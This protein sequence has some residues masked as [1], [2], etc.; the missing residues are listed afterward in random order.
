MLCSTCT[1][2][3]ADDSK[4]C[5]KCGA[6]IDALANRSTETAATSEIVENSFPPVTL[7][8]SQAPPPYAAFVSMAL[9]LGLC[10]SVV[11]FNAAHNIGQASWRVSPISLIA[12]VVAVVLMMGMPGMWRRTES[13]PDEP[14][15]HKKLLRR[16]AFFVLLFVATA[17]VVGAKVG[18][19]G[20]EAGQLIADFREMSRIGHRISSARNSVEP[21]VPAQI[22]MYKQIEPEVRDFDAVLKRIQAELPVYDEKFTDQHEQILKSIDSINLG[23]KRASLLQQQIAVARDI[24]SLDPAPRIQAWKDR[25]QPLLDAETALD[26]D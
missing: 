22:V 8:A 5:V 16:S 6:P 26:K 25:M 4:S 19:D 24:E 20:R 13:H 23:L 17:A 12:S 9:G 21:N 14:G 1:T 3:L 2:E 10:L 15:D 11:T 18:K 7:A